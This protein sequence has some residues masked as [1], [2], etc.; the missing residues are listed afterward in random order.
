MH[1]CT[2]GPGRSGFS[3][4]RLL[5][6][7]LVFLETEAGPAVQFLLLLGEV[8]SSRGAGPG[9][10]DVVHLQ[11]NNIKKRPCAVMVVRFYTMLF[12]I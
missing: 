8:V 4:L 1:L 9:L 3:R 12:C 7:L 2:D 10:Q 6:A 5:A 11:T